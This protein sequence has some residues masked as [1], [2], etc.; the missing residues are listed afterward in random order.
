MQL[1]PKNKKHFMF[2]WMTDRCEQIS[3]IYKQRP[4]IEPSRLLCSMIQKRSLFAHHCFKNVVYMSCVNNTSTISHLTLM[5]M[6]VM[7]IH[8]GILGSRIQMSACMEY[9]RFNPK[10]LLS[11]VGLTETCFSTTQNIVIGLSELYWSVWMMKG[12]S[13]RSIQSF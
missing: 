9:E 10:C 6:V 2:R 12:C 8:D 4:L 1:S 7:M 13:F 3:C 5:K 11:L